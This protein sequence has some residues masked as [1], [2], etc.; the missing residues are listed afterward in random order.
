MEVAIVFIS[1]FIVVFGIFY[2]HY[3]TRNK[4]RLALIEKGQD[5]SLFYGDKTQK[6]SPVWKIIILN[7]G[8]ISIGVGLGIFVGALFTQMMGMMDKTAYPAFVFLF[9]GIGLLV[10][11]FITK[12][13][14]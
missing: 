4:E 3:S 6:T 7:L 1:L 12:K 11:F 8:L 10:G 2:L 5:V 9:S 13:M 14:D